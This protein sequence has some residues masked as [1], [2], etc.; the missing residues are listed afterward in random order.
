[1]ANMQTQVGDFGFCVDGGSEA[2]QIIPSGT[3]DHRA[4]VS[5]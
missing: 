4:P 5:A 2:A 3:E 1:M